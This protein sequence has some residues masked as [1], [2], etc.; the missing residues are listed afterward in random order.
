MLAEYSLFSLALFSFPSVY[1]ICVMSGDLVDPF[2]E[3]SQWIQR[4]PS[5]FALM[6]SR[7]VSA[8]DS[9]SSLQRLLGFS[10]CAHTTQTALIDDLLD[11]AKVSRN[12]LEVHLQPGTSLHTRIFFFFVVVY[13]FH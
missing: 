8:S 13:F 9:R 6:R 4:S 3:E 1:D 7:S 5:A 11:W 10:A 12:K 2:S